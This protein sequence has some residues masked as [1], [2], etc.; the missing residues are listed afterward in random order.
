[1]ELNELKAKWNELDTRLTQVETVNNQAVKEL[2]RLRT[3]SVFTQHRIRL[4]FEFVIATI[5]TTF[6]L[7][8]FRRESEMTHILNPLSIQ[9]LIGWLVLTCIYA[10]YRCIRFGG[11]DI[12]KPTT[13][14]MKLSNQYKREYSIRRILGYPLFGALLLAFLFF[15]RSWIIERGRIVP[16]IIWAICIMAFFIWSMTL[17]LRRQKKSIE[18]VD[19]NLKELAEIM[20]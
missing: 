20:E 8:T 17:E 19:N 3:N 9:M 18:E 4:W 2:T 15:E 7:L 14:L 6:M 1:M 10:L 5:V 16:V 12:T 13:E 11:F